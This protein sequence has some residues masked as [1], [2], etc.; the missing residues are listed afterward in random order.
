MLISS[1]ICLYG[2]ISRSFL[3]LTQ[4]LLMTCDVN[5]LRLLSLSPS[6]FYLAFLRFLCV[7]CSLSP[8]CVVSVV[9]CNGGVSICSLMDLVHSF[10]IRI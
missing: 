10:L 4:S 6:L 1:F 2:A 5:F 3:A 7:R 9:L 8:V